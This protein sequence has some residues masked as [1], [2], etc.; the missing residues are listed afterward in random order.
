MN[1]PERAM[2]QEDSDDMPPEVDFSGGVRGKYRARYLREETRI[3]CG[4]RGRDGTE[5][6]EALKALVREDLQVR[7]LPPL[8]VA[9]AI[10]LTNDDS[11]RTG[12]DIGILDSATCG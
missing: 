10:T 9:A 2:H 6:V 1:C 12:S 3:T 4:E 8:P 5:N 11:A 7:I